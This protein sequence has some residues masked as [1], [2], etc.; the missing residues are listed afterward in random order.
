MQTLKNYISQSEKHS[1]EYITEAKESGPGCFLMT[2]LKGVKTPKETIVEFLRNLEMKDLKE[3]SDYIDSKDSKNY[4]AYK[5]ADD[6]FVQ[7]SNKEQVIDKIAQY[8]HK[9]IAL[10]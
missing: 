9:Y 10:A 2:V 1:S 8:L 7:N 4:M 6:E 3:A 5:P